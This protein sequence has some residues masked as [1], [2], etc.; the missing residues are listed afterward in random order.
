MSDISAD[1]QALR[2]AV[3]RADLN[4]KTKQSFWETPKAILLIIATTA[5]IAGFLGFKVGGQPQ[6]I[7]VHLDAP[8]ALQRTAP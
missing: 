2:I 4:L 5:A 7:T 1:E 6:Q 3:M 8:L